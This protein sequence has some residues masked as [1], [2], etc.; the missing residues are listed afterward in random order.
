[1]LRHPFIIHQFS[2]I[3]LK[4]NTL[5]KCLKIIFILTLRTYFQ[6]SVDNNIPQKRL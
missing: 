4:K 6:L 5:K 3:N 2:N 1:M